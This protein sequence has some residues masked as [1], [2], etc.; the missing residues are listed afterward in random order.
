VTTLSEGP[1]PIEPAAGVY[2]ETPAATPDPDGCAQ[3]YPG[4]ESYTARA[5]SPR[6]EVLNNGE[7]LQPPEG[8]GSSSGSFGGHVPES[9]LFTA[10]VAGTVHPAVPDMELVVEVGGVDADGGQG[11]NVDEASV[12]AV[13]GEPP[14]GSSQPPGLITRP[15]SPPGPVTPDSATIPTHPSTHWARC[16]NCIGRRADNGP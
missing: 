5:A 2:V 7:D 10:A 12:E 9:A 13:C 15:P 14:C 3:S 8:L 11:Q 1:A 6:R 16:I 4:H